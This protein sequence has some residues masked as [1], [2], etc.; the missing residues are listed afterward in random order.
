MNALNR[1]MAGALVALM[2]VAATGCNE[3]PTDPVNPGTLGAPTGLQASSMSATS[4]GLRWN[5]VT[6]A[7]SYLVSWTPV[8]NPA[9]QSGNVTVSTTSAAANNLTAGVRYTFSVQGVNADGNGTA[10]TMDW[11][12]AGRYTQNT[13]GADAA[14]PSTTLRIYEF[15]SQYGS[16]VVLNPALGGPK[17]VSTVVERPGLVQLAIFV[18]GDNVIIGSAGG[19]PEYRGVN[20]PAKFDQ[21]VFIS[22]TTFAVNSLN[23]WYVANP[24]NTYIDSVDGNVSAFTIPNASTNVGQGFFVRIGTA[25]AYNY[26]RVLVKTGANN[27][28]LQGSGNNRYV[29]L[30]VSYQTTPNLPFAKGVARKESPVGYYSQR[31]F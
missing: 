15:D 13:G 10:A 9:A 20:N 11:A 19:F 23:E 18:T 24:I 3:N 5:A 14:N 7:T 12:G 21:N 26:A 2:G 16:G 4:V 30:E 31:L 27:R 28:I 25:G 17:T 6:G 29:E 1:L 22:N 8:G